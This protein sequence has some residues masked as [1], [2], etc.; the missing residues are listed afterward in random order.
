ME[1][2]QCYYVLKRIPTLFAWQ[3][4]I[5]LNDIIKR[6]KA[7]ILRKHSYCSTALSLLHTILAHHFTV[8]VCLFII[9]IFHC[10]LLSN[11]YVI[12][13]NK[14][15]NNKIQVLFLLSILFR[16]YFNFPFR[17]IGVKVNYKDCYLPYQ[18]IFSF[19]LMHSIV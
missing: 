6:T 16:S 8:Y 9:I 3:L 18:N 11:L 10:L 1:F 15:F 12:N 19:I 2:S 5:K 14:I 13:N 7:N 17:V 4:E